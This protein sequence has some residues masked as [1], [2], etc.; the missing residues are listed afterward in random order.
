MNSHLRLQP[1]ALIQNMRTNKKLFVVLGYRMCAGI[2]HE[3]FEQMKLLDS[4]GETFYCS[5][6]YKDHTPGFKHWVV[7]Q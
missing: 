2:M 5:A 1:G 3:D 6:I 7:V 4:N